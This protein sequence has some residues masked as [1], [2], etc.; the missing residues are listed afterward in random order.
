[1]PSNKVE[2]NIEKIQSIVQSDKCMYKKV[3]TL[4]KESE[5]DK[6]IFSKLMEMKMVESYK[7]HS[8]SKIKGIS[9]F[10]LPE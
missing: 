9:L 7:K 10:K 6:D 4:Q 2:S 8:T 3:S 1:M 5:K